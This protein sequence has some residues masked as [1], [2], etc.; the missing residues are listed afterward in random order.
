MGI[1]D[2]LKEL[3]KNCPKLSDKSQERL[4]KALK[5][6]HNNHKS[7]DIKNLSDEYSNLLTQIVPYKESYDATE[8]LKKLQQRNK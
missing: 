5:I 8:I 3:S 7:S 1:T 2:E 6:L 4:D